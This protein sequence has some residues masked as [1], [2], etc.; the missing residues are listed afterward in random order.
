[1]FYIKI[2]LEGVVESQFLTT[3]SLDH[4]IE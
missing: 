2:P 1:V 3:A 4:R